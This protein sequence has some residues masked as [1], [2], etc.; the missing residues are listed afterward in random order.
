MVPRGSGFRKVTRR[1]IEQVLL[2]QVED[3]GFLW[4]LRRRVVLAPNPLLRDIVRLDERVAA[5]IDA[6]CVAGDVGWLRAHEALMQAQ[7]GALFACCVLAIESGN[8][9]RFVDIITACAGVDANVS[10]DADANPSHEPIAALC[11]AAHDPA[12]QLVDRLGQ[13]AKLCLR[14]IAISS[15][16]ARRTDPGPFLITALSD[17][18]WSVPAPTAPPASSAAA[19]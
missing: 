18:P 6:L 19:T 9:E 11:W 7:A 1:V 2:Q 10:V 5:H 14:A 12:A 3:A 15:S 13:A 4:L 8:V 16:G 17:P